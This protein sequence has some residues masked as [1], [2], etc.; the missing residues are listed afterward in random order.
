MGNDMQT[1][2][3]WNVTGWAVLGMVAIAVLS[4]IL[5]FGPTEVEV[6]KSVLNA[7]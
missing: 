1:N 6:A 2:S 5:G 3:C 7:S 4:F